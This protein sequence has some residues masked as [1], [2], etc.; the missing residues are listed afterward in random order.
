MRVPALLALLLSS[1]IALAQTPVMHEPETVYSDAERDRDESVS[2]RTVT[3]VLSPADTTD[4]Q[5]ARWKLPVCFNVYGLAPV[6]KYLVET[7]MKQVARQVG[8]PVD[9]RENCDTNILIAFTSDQKATLQSIADVRPWL[10]PGLSMIRN[11]VRESQPI[12]AWYALGMTGKTG[13]AMLVYDGYEY[14]PQYIPATTLTRLD[15][16]LETQIMA[17]TMVVDTKAIMGMKL[18]TL[19]DYF[20][21]HSLAQIQTRQQCRAV[22]TIANLMQ[23]GC[24]P[25]LAADHI[26]KGDLAMLTGI[27]QT[28]DDSMQRIQKMRIIGNMRRSLESQTTGKPVPL[29]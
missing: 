26:T 27:Y 3:D 18:E 29:Q 1:S 24:D 7:R 9:G 8:A 25:A 19:A 13:R 16:G 14:E 2:R 20:A 23:V 21:L 10:V 5:Y 17:V 6:A 28:P 12:Q 11:R 22:E 4:D 15:T